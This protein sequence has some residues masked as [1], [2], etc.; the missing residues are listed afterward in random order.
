MSMSTDKIIRIGFFVAVALAV[1]VSM[2]VALN[3]KFSSAILTPK[4]YFLLNW[5]NIAFLLAFTGFAIYRKSIQLFLV[6][7][8]ISFLLF[9]LMRFDFGFVPKF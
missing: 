9:L 4:I 8:V 3:L 1:V 5:V 2:D 6:F 7:F